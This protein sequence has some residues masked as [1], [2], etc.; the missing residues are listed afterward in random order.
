M[1]DIQLMSLLYLSAG[2]FVCGVGYRTTIGSLC[3]CDSC[4]VHIEP[5]LGDEGNADYW[6]ESTQM[7]WYPDR[8][9]FVAVLWDFVNK[10]TCYGSYAEHESNTCHDL[11]WIEPTPEG[12]RWLLTFS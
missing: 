8:D 10:K 4:C 11:G 1:S 9:N 2:C 12:V 5:I 3:V 7:S 6:H